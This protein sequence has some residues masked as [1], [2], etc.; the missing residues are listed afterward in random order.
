MIVPH[1]VT[2]PTILYGLQWQSPG[3]LIQPWATGLCPQALITAS[4]KASS[5]QVGRKS[6]DSFM[7]S[8]GQIS[9]GMNFVQ[10]IAG[11]PDTMPL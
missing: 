2:R 8:S 7:T 5:L 6:C 4:V 1:G 3:S 10:L 11:A 9:A